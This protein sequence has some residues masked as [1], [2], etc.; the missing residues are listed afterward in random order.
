MDSD[1]IIAA[2]Y[3]KLLS[4]SI[5]IGWVNF[6]KKYESISFDNETLIISKLVLLHPIHFE[7]LSNQQQSKLSI[8]S[9]IINIQG[10]RSF[11]RSEIIVNCQ[12][13]QIWGYECP[14]INEPKVLDHDFP[15]SLGGPTREHNKRILCRWHNMIKANDIH[16]Y[17]W[18]KIFKDYNFYKLQKREHWIDS[19]VLKIKKIFNINT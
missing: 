19:Q 2:Q 7:E 9:K 16:N 8:E 5:Y 12:S 1:N 17:N 4:E 11:S 10:N 13:K 18:Q 3:V 6:E 14:F 15:Y